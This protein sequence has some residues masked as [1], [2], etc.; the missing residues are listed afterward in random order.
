M[1]EDG[2]Y[3]LCL[4]IFRDPSI[5]D[6]ERYDLAWEVLR[7]N[8][9]Q[10]DRRLE[11]QR[12][13]IFLRC[14]EQVEEERE[15]IARMQRRQQQQQQEQPAAIE[16]SQESRSIEGIAPGKSNS[17]LV[18]LMVD[19][20]TDSVKEATPPPPPPVQGVPSSSGPAGGSTL[21]GFARNFH[22][23]VPG[24]ISHPPPP[25]PLPPRVAYA[26]RA[27]RVDA[28][29]T[30]LDNQLRGLNDQMRSLTAEI[31]AAE[32]ARDQA[33]QRFATE[34]RE[35]NLTMAHGQGYDQ[36]ARGTALDDRVA[37]LR[38]AREGVMREIGNLQRQRNGL[39]DDF[40][41]GF[42]EE[43]PRR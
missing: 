33:F 42:G 32:P 21:H 39:Y 31:Q 9:A 22:E 8:S 27:Q 17:G 36:V 12:A 10:R 18:Q 16:T 5:E 4:P 26:N 19:T 14:R 13:R 41:P 35:S 25:P 6:E 1:E 15:E 37:E 29:I 3:H 43:G 20:K 34:G 28:D 30:S 23:F 38:R 7:S 24:R 40:M 2:L 11:E